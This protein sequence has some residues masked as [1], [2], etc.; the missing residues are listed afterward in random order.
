[1]HLPVTSLPLHIPLIRR[2]CLRQTDSSVGAAGDMKDHAQS[3]PVKRLLTAP[4]SINLQAGY[5]RL[6]C[7]R[8]L[9]PD[10]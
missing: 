4:C 3:G 2:R 9:H 1:M 5:Y 10:H 8:S 7:K 6:Y